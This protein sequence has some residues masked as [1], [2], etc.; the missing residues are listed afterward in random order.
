MAIQFSVGYR[1]NLLDS[2]ETTV[3]TIPR[4]NLY[5]GTQPSS[6]SVADTGELASILLPS[7]W[8]NVASGGSKT[9]LGTWT[10]SATGGGTVGHFRLIDSAS[11]CHMQGNVTA[12]AGGGDMTLDN[13]NVSASQTITVTTFS[14]TAPGV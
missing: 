7:D 8:M 11:A 12:T 5:S 9:L 13:T 1:N 10:G 2:L 3:G 14:L 4:L 6:A